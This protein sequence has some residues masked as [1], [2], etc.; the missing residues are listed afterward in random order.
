MT[1]QGWVP[2][3]RAPQ[4]NVP[5]P[6]NVNR[7]AQI[8]QLHEDL[9]HEDG[10][11][12]VGARAAIGDLL[13]EVSRLRD[14]I[15]SIGGDPD[16]APAFHHADEGGDRL[17]IDIHVNRDGLPVVAVTLASDGVEPLCAH[18]T[19]DRVDEAV[20]GL[21]EAQSKAAAGRHL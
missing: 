18:L 6:M 1:K 21:R 17:V 3:F 12:A 10:L 11:A 5:E 14:T 20:A 2:R 8:R 4:A 13:K 9:G 16:E 15:R 7:E 19:D